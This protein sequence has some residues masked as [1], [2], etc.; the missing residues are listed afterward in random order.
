MR[1]SCSSTRIRFVPF[2]SV[3]KCRLWGRFRKRKIKHV[4]DRRSSQNDRPT[5]A[6]QHRAKRALSY[7]ISQRHLAVITDELNCNASVASVSDPAWVEQGSGYQGDAHD[8]NVLI[9]VLAR[10]HWARLH[11]VRLR[12]ARHDHVERR[13]IEDLPQREEHGRSHH[14]PRLAARHCHHGEARQQAAVAK[15]LEA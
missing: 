4:S 5:S 9:E 15:K 11:S 8:A 3:Q 2:R 14:S 12:I 13:H 6:L 1:A 7:R 10:H